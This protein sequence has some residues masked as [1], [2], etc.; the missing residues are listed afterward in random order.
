M[1]LRSRFATGGVVAVAAAKGSATADVLT[2]STKRAAKRR[3][4]K[5]E[6]EAEPSKRPRLTSNPVDRSKSSFKPHA[7]WAEMLDA[8]KHMRSQTQAPVDMMGCERVADVA[9]SPKDQRY[10]ALLGLMLSSQT[11]DPVTFEAMQ[12][13]KRHG[14]TAQNIINTP[15]SVL[16]ELIKKVGFHNKKTTYIKQATQILLDKYD[17]DIP[18]SIEEMCK[19]PGVGPKMAYILM[20][21]G[22]NRVEGIGVD[23]H[24]HRIS[25]RLGFVP[26]TVKTPEDTRKALEGWL[27]FEHWSTINLLLVGFG[28]TICTPVSPNCEACHINNTCP[29]AFKA[30]GKK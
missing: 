11:K 15:D 27:P 21:V 18:P 1:Q 4:I 26:K 6:Y 9:A 24:V 19:L 7:K 20:S 3:P 2:Q 10:Q 17:G 23:V 8:I 28:Q 5:I 16:N 30:R 12:N 25:Q 13:L 14:C 22:W 29:S